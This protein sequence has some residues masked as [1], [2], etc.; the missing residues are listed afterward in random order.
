MLLQ[1]N[2]PMGQVEFASLDASAYTVLVAILN[3]SSGSSTRTGQESRGGEGMSDTASWPRL[4]FLPHIIDYF[5]KPAA[6][7]RVRC[8]E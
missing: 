2:R 4:I 5:L 1:K 7:C 3:R 6:P 8:G